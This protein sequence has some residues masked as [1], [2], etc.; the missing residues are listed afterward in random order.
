MSDLKNF[1][2][3]FF[4][5]HIFSLN[6]RFSNPAKFLH[7]AWVVWLP[8]F[9]YLFYFCRFILIWTNAYFFVLYVSNPSG[10]PYFHDFDRNVWW[11]TNDNYLN[12]SRS[13]RLTIPGGRNNPWASK[14]DHL[15]TKIPCKTQFLI[16]KSHMVVCL[17]W[18]AFKLVVVLWR[19]R[20]LVI[21]FWFE[22]C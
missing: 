15:T 1:C 7:L 12:L 19:N 2:V 8:S 11:T 21:R 13:I 18:N 9:A 22:S 3:S 5:I 17:V 20:L 16:L 6:G 14:N 4:S 10:H